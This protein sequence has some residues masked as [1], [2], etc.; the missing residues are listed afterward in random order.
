MRN[1]HQ[2]ELEMYGDSPELR[3]HQA[4]ERYELRHEQWHE[5]HGD[6]SASEGRAHGSARDG[7]YDYYERLSACGY[8]LP[9]GSLIVAA[10]TGQGDSQ[11][12]RFWPETGRE[13]ALP[14]FVDRT[15]DD[16]PVAVFSDGKEVA[17]FGFRSAS[18]PGYGLFAL[19]LQ[20]KTARALSVEI[21]DQGRFRQ[22][23]T[24]D[25]KSL[26]IT[27][28]VEDVQFQTFRNQQVVNDGLRLP[29]EDS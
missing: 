26:L 15:A 1:H 5:R 16:P 3:E 22:T 13:D 18:Q 23:V 10:V 28:R 2:K 20:S 19:D 9:E 27:T 6:S 14:A 24:P 12:R 17:F 8:P 21:T 11:L 29:N 25:G 4:Q 7:Q